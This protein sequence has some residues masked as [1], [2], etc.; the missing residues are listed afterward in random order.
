M[1]VSENVHLVESFNKNMNLVS[2][3]G[4]ENRSVITNL[5]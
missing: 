5:V 2:Q 1:I 3:S 4:L